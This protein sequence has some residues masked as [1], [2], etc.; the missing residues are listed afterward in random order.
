MVDPIFLF[1]GGFYK[2][3]IDDERLRVPLTPHEIDSVFYDPHVPRDTD[4]SIKTELNMARYADLFCDLEAGDEIYVGLVPD[5]AIYRGLWAMSFNAVAGFKVTFDLV[6]ARD[7]YNAV[8][9]NQSLK[10]LPA[11]DGTTDLPY[12]FANGLGDASCDAMIK[13]ELPYGGDYDSYRNNTALAFAPIDPAKFAPLGEAMYIRMTI[14]EMGEL[15]VDPDDPCCSHCNKPKYPTFEVGALYD[16]LCA[17][18]QRL[19]KY[20]NCDYSLCNEGCDG[21]SPGQASY[22]LVPVNYVSS[23]EETLRPETFVRVAPGQTVQVTA[24]TI[25]GYTVDPATQSVTNTNGTVTPA[26]VTFTYT[27]V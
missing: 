21:G 15:G 26:T 20:C 27:S 4:N 19:Q 7:V 14:D 23:T 18:K 25:T 12:D 13:A 10:G 6:R 24:P 1:N 16:R 17:D 2:R 9:N 3:G 8:V 11:A 5:A 22:E